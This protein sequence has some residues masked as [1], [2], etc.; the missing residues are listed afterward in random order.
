MEHPHWQEEQEHLTQTLE[1]V[2]GELRKCESALGIQNGNDRIIMVQDDSSSDAVVQQQIMRMTLQTLHQ[3][4]LYIP[5]LQRF[6]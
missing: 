6:L 3:L 4:R 1:T 5:F 2:E